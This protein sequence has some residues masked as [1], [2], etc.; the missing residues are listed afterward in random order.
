MNYLAIRIIYTQPALEGGDVKLGLITDVIISNNFSI[1]SLVN[2]ETPA[3]V[4]VDAIAKAIGNVSANENHGS[5][6]NA[7]KF[8]GPHDLTFAFSCLEIKI[9]P[10]Y[11]QI[12]SR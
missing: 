10:G 3:E 9:N 7:V 12:L 2:E 11:R 8:E 4:D 5:V 1:T 6:D